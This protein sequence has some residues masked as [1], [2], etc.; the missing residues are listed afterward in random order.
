[1]EG[2]KELRFSFQLLLVSFA[3]MLFLPGLLQGDFSSIF[4]RGLFTLILFSCLYLVANRRQD[5]ITGVVLALPA[6]ITNW[7]PAWF[8]DEKMQILAHSFFQTVFL[9]Y[10]ILKIAGYLVAA[11]KID[12]EIIYAAICLYLLMGVTW[13]MVYFSIVLIEP[14]AISLKVDSI[15]SDRE[16]L[17]VI[18]HE[19]VYFSYVTQTT[20]GYGDVTPVSPIA[21]AFVIAQSLVGQI[22]IA[23]IIAR[24]VGLQ[25]AAGMNENSDPKDDI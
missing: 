15:L 24:L 11:R 22:Y 17:T 7:A 10:I 2:S 4:S 21:R 19:L 1:M 16:S 20:L 3:L 23:V 18:L 5:L 8:T 6:V 14:E 12:S 13:A 25:I 9:I